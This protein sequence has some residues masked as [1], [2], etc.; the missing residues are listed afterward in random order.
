MVRNCSQG[1]GSCSTPA[2]RSSTAS[3]LCSASPCS[4]ARGLGPTGRSLA[5]PGYCCSCSWRVSSTSG[6]S[7]GST[8]A[9]PRGWTS[10]PTSWGPR[11]SSPRSLPWGRARRRRPAGSELRCLIAGFVAC[12]LAGGLSTV[13]VCSRRSA[14]ASG[15]RCSVRSRQGSAPRRLGPRPPPRAELV[16]RQRPLTRLAMETRGP[17]HGPG[18]GPPGRGRARAGRE[19]SDATGAPSPRGAGTCRPLLSSPPLGPG[20]P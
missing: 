5:L 14:R 11:R 16:L 15:A 20:R 8:D 17:P 9:L 4:A 2:T 3:S 6:T 13:L 19:S 1:S 18:L 12:W 7:P 10:S